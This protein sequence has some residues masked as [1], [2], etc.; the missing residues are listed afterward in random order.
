MER[1][2]TTNSLKISETLP[3]REMLMWLII[4]KYTLYS[5]VWEEW[6]WQEIKTR[7]EATLLLFYIS[8]SF[9]HPAHLIPHHPAAGTGDPGA[10]SYFT[11]LKNFYVGRG[12]A[13][14]VSFDL[15]I[16]LLGIY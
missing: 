4:R 3:D 15:V 12:I 7:I 13:T 2:F 16:L 5:D 11:L 8:E 9:S 14:L 10:I 1:V 6:H